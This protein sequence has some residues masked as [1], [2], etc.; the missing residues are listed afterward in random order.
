MATSFNHFQAIADALPG[1][2]GEIV[3]VTAKDCVTN[4]Q[5]QMLS[6]GQYK[7]GNMHDSTHVENGPDEQ[8]RFVIVGAP[9]GIYQNYGTRFMPGKPFFE[10]GIEATRP[11]FEWRLSSI[12]SRLPH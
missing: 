8:T 1:I 6:N 5:L 10:P 12:E 11:I 2:C 3:S 7:S 9:Y 4:I